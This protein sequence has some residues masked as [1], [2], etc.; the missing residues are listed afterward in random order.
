VSEGPIAFAPVF[1]E[2][3]APGGASRAVIR[4]AFD[5]ILSGAWTPVQVA[6][7][8]VALRMRGED[9]TTIAAAAEA[10]RAVMVEVDHGLPAVLDTCGTGGDG[11]GTLNLSTAA[12]VVVAACGQPV[13]KHGNRSVSSRAGS[14]DVLEALDL[15]IDVPPAR[16][17]EVLRRA[18]I[19]FLFAPAH[20]PAMRHA[21][22]ARRELALR[23]VFNAL[24]PIANPARAT[25]Q[26]IGT[27]DHGLRAI[28]ASTLS[29]L[30]SRRAWIV[31]GE[32]GLDEVSPFGPTHVTELVGGEIRERVIRPED[33]GLCPSPPGAIKGGDA[34]ENAASI[35]AILRGEAHPAREAVI[36]NAAA[37]LAVARESTEAN[38]LPAFAAEAAETI[39]NGRAMR[40][41]EAWRRAARQARTEAP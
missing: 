26:L 1:E 18:N 14:A 15:P 10:M 33:F 39:A 29:E 21:A 27:Y 22:Q 5:A 13:A 37:A 20:H 6:G 9:A 28:L 31:R 41:L 16:Q 24:G 2:I 8:A 3:C 34:A 35:L 17:A 40:T 36:L 25:H 23:T 4:R 38:A 19:T 32:D 7:F 12:A 30:G 11:L